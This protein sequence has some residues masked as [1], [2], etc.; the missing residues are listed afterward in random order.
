MK[1]FIPIY[2]F[3]II[4]S[5]T[6]ITSQPAQS[7]NLKRNNNRAFVTSSGNSTSDR[8]HQVE[9]I[10][11][12]K[13]G[14]KGNMELN[15]DFDC[16]SINCRTTLYDDDGLASIIAVIS[17]IRREARC[18]P[19]NTIRQQDWDVIKSFL[20]ER[21]EHLKN[22]CREK[23]CQNPDT[24]LSIGKGLYPTNI[25][26]H[27]GHVVS[28]INPFLKHVDPSTPSPINIPRGTHESLHLSDSLYNSMED[29][30]EYHIYR[31]SPRPNPQNFVSGENVISTR[32]THIAEHHSKIHSIKNT[33]SNLCHGVWQGRLANLLGPLPSRPI[34]GSGRLPQG[35]KPRQKIRRKPLPSRPINVRGVLQGP[36]LPS[37][38]GGIR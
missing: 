35:I 7:R 10:T 14:K 30:G 2:L 25:M 15:F 8:S 5:I 37:S 6:F 36:R 23:I 22:Y 18:D 17:E 21:A 24:E 33:K 28:I 32:E 27:C 3:L 38:G 19:S 11:G 13:T 4:F 16:D 20:R 26:E 29:V 12:V 34:V 1:S 9:G 31:V